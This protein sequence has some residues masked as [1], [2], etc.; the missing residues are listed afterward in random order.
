M[1]DN[2]QKKLNI[3]KTKEEKIVKTEKV[4]PVAQPAS[5]TEPKK[6]N[7]LEI[8]VNNESVH[9]ESLDINKNLG[10]FENSFDPNED[11]IKQID[12]EIVINEESNKLGSVRE[13]D[14]KVDFAKFSRTKKKQKHTYKPGTNNFAIRIDAWLRNDRSMHVIWILAASIIAIILSISI[15]FFTVIS[16]DQA[17]ASDKG[18]WNLDSF[19]TIALCAKTFSGLAIGVVVLPL[20]YLLITVLV[21]INNTYRSRQFHYFLWVCLII[22]FVFTIVTIPLGSY[23]IIINNNF[24]PPSS[25]IQRL[26]ALFNWLIK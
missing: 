6:E 7:V 21:G 10:S 25:S 4:K 24:V 26:S 18:Y 17:S 19:K 16:L 5:S 11:P 2:K 15:V 1:D 12:E 9:N 13:E 3:E 20:V 8:K 23:I 14:K 22:G